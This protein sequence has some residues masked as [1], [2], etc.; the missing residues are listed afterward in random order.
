[1]HCR[2]AGLG[3]AGDQDVEACDDT[4]MQ[5]TGGRCDERAE[6]DQV[7][8]VGRLDH[9]LANIVVEALR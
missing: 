5:E 9:E 4:G 6:P 2:V 8:E 1:M 3:T 7:V